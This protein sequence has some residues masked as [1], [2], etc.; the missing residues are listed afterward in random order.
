MTIQ[1]AELFAVHH[2]ALVAQSGT[3]APIALARNVVSLR[4]T[5]QRLAGKE[6]FSDLSLERRAV[7]SVLCHG[8]H[9]SEA[10]QGVNSN[11]SSVH[12]QGRTPFSG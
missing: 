6:F 1:A 5:V 12:R 7:R 2:Y 11:R 8:F 4:Q 3:N 9:P 10:Q